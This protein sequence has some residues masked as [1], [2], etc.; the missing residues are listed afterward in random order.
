VI[1]AVPSQWA[2]EKIANV[3]Y[4]LGKAATAVVAVATVGSFNLMWFLQLS[5][6]MIWGLINVIQMILI[7]PLVQVVYPVN[8]LVINS[9]LLTIANFEILPSERISSKLFKFGA[10]IP[11]SDSFQ[12]FG[13]SSPFLIFNMGTSF[14]IFFG[15]I[16]VLPMVKWIGYCI[17]KRYGRQHPK[18]Q[19]FYL[20]LKSYLEYGFFI[21]MMFEMY[22][23]LAVTSFVNLCEMNQSLD[24]WLL[25]GNILSGVFAIIG[26]II[27]AV[28]PLYF[29]NVLFSKKDNLES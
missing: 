24:T 9:A 27:V 4:N 25:T 12:R 6:A 26:T 19:K 11:L 8:A 15:S 21:R 23:D 5:M 1:K 7:L 3:F 13:F 2:D 28:A 18:I 29:A 14:F 16:I 17:E 20:K 10:L 22:L